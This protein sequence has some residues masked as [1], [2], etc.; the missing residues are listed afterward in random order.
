MLRVV[1]LLAALLVLLFDAE[2][3]CNTIPANITR[4]GTSNHVLRLMFIVDPYSVLIVVLEKIS[5]VF[6]KIRK[7]ESLLC[8][9]SLVDNY[10]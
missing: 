3:P 5:T 8:T 7:K 1:S 6:C 4:P 9:T 10:S 2:H